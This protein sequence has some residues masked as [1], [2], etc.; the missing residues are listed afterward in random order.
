MKRDILEPLEEFRDFPKRCI[1][2]SKRVK[3][4]QAPTSINPE[5]SRSLSTPKSEGKRTSSVQSEPQS[6][7][8]YFNV[9]SLVRTIPGSGKYSS[10]YSMLLINLPSNKEKQNKKSLACT[11]LSTLATYYFSYFKKILI[12]NGCMFVSYKR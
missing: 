12:S 5:L 2:L 11:S 1:I 4:V 8:K 10:L 3:V 7:S 9:L 6:Q